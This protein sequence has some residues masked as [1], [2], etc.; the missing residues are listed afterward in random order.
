MCG[1]AVG[2]E[3]GCGLSSD[4]ECLGSC[5]DYGGVGGGLVRSSPVGWCNCFVSFG[6]GYALSWGVG[7]SCW[8]CWGVIRVLVRTL[9]LR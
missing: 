4:A 1:D 6:L 2:R 5:G 9:R 8:V 3:G 7:S